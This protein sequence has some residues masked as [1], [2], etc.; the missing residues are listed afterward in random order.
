MGRDVEALWKER[1][2]LNAFLIEPYFVPDL[3]LYVYQKTRY[4]KDSQ[5]PGLIFT[6]LFFPSFIV[7]RFNQN[8]NDFLFLSTKLKLIKL[9]FI[10]IYMLFHLQAQLLLICSILEKIL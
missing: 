4:Y 8:L 1:L 7:S 9:C 6:A 3:Y 5:F 2:K 10:S